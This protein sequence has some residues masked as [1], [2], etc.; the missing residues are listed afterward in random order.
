MPRVSSRHE[1]QIAT[2]GHVFA[3]LTS[4]RRHNEQVLDESVATPWSAALAMQ[5][6]QM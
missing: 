4:A 6:S 1:V 5:D 3:N 2:F